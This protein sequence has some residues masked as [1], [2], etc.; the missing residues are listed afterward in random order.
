MPSP[1]S[2]ADWGEIVTAW[3]PPSQVSASRSLTREPLMNQ[4]PGQANSGRGRLDLRSHA[5]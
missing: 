3:K 5:L 1:V 2:R 4:W